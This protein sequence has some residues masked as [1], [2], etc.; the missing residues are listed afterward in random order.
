[1]SWY[2]RGVVMSFLFG[3]AVLLAAFFMNPT[4]PGFPWVSIAILIGFF[5]L[6]FKKILPLFPG[7][8]PEGRIIPPL[9]KQQQNEREGLDRDHRG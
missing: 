3:V 2:F 9:H 5:F 1:M 6:P 4:F 8:K 7:T